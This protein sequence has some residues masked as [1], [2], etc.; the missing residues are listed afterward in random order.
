[1]DYDMYLFSCL[2]KLYDKDFDEQPYD[3]QFDILPK[4]YAEFE[5][6]LFN[7][8]NKSAY[9]CMINFFESNLN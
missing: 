6:S 1:M 2:L 9:D 3:Y 5:Q 8:T 7:D 4:K